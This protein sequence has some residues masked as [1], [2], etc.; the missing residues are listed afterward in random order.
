MLEMPYAQQRADLQLAATLDE[1]AHLQR[2]PRG[3]AIYSRRD[4]QR[5]RNVALDGN[6]GEMVVACWARQRDARVESDQLR[7]CK[8]VRC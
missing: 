1:V 2:N 5:I 4:G 8:H 3:A 6:A 7:Q